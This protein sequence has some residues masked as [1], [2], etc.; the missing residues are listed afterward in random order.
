[1]E[2]AALYS[3]KEVV[4]KLKAKGATGDIGC[5]YWAIRGGNLAIWSGEVPMDRPELVHWAAYNDL[6][7]VLEEFRKRGIDLTNPDQ[8]GAT[9]I[10]IAVVNKSY[11]AY[12]YLLGLGMLPSPGKL[13]G[14]DSKA[15]NRLYQRIAAPR[16][17]PHP[18]FAFVL[19]LILQYYLFNEYSESVL[20]FC[21]LLFF[22]AL[23]CGPPP[24]PR[25]DQPRVLHFYSKLLRNKIQWGN[26]HVVYLL[27]NLAVGVIGF[28]VVINAVIDGYVAAFA[29]W[30]VLFSVALFLANFLLEV[31]CIS[32]NL[33]HS[34]M[35]Q[36]QLHPE[37]YRKLKIVKELGL[38]YH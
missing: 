21:E 30:V 10:D 6:P 14:V 18:I 11:R 27:F 9:P 15:M 20:L 5:D 13:A 29:Y 19:L 32:R 38:V 33:T 26:N 28:Y 4:D 37:L 34:E 16:K 25:L 1:M 2:I 24:K 35:F 8:N 3:T 7:E 31:W 12:K 22:V 36:R 17:Y 23:S